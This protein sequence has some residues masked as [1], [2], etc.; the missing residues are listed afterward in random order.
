MSYNIA[1]DTSHNPRGRLDENFIQLTK[2]LNINNF[3]CTKLF[4]PLITQKLLKSYD[5][6]VF[7]CPDF[8]QIILQE[9]LEIKNWIAKEGG[10]LL[11]LSHAGGDRGRKTNLSELSEQFGVLFENNQVLDAEHNYGWENLPVTS[12]IVFDHL[13][14]RGIKEICFRAGCSLNIIG[15][16]QAVILSNSSSQPSKTP[17]ISASK[18]GQGRI[19]CCGSYEIFRD[20]IKGG[21]RFPSHPSLAL[22][23]FNWL[24]SDEEV[25]IKAQAP[26]VTSEKEVQINNNVVITPMKE[27]KIEFTEIHRDP[28]DIEAELGALK[29]KL[30]SE[31]KILNYLEGKLKSGELEQVKYQSLKANYDSKITQ[32]NKRIKYLQFGLKKLQSNN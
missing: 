13:I 25:L 20:G 9:I 23:I 22:N 10:N 2:L 27:G 28:E 12:E 8:S 32:I 19:V 18:L 16:A 3:R 29:E 11:L 7:A 14:T 4:E 6:L 31:N 21:F 26:V 30:K 15:E 1:F 5:I 24:I 17:L